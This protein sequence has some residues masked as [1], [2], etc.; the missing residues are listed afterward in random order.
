LAEQTQRV[1]IGLDTQRAAL[2]ATADALWRE[3]DRRTEEAE[4]Q[5]VRLDDALISVRFGA[6]DVREQSAQAAEGLR[7]LLSTATDKLETLAAAARDHRLELETAAETSL[8]RVASELIGGR[9]RWSKK[10]PRWIARYRRRRARRSGR[11]SAS[12]RPRGGVSTFY[13][14]RWLKVIRRSPT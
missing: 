14:P 1:E 3:H 7:D 8:A 5:R 13:R 2:A 11:P 4:A 9:R 10:Q 6:A 12:P